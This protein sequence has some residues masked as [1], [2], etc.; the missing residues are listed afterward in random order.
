M[1]LDNL[2][3][4]ICH[5]I[6]PTNLIG[7]IMNQTPLGII[8]K[9]SHNI[10]DKWKK[11]IQNYK[12]HS[13]IFMNTSSIFFFCLRL[14]GHN[15]LSIWVDIYVHAQTYVPKRIETNIGR[16][17]LHISYTVLYYFMLYGLI[18]WLVFLWIW[19]LISQLPFLHFLVCSSTLFLLQS[20]C[21]V[22][23]VALMSPSCCH[24][25]SYLLLMNNNM[26]IISCVHFIFH[27]LMTFNHYLLIWPKWGI[28]KSMIEHS[29]T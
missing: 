28:N 10:S 8:I 15:S 6:Q 19:A 5:K 4:L 1:A 23:I 21:L 27:S 7:H 3:G 14:D 2:Q 11:F 17:N 22:A 16:K 24:L 18:L 20:F 26:T 12:L 9:W 29:T 25:C 13:E